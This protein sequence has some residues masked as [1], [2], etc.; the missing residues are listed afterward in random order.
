MNL[1]PKI[2][3]KSGMNY[4]QVFRDGNVAIYRQTKAG[5]SWEAFEV[6][7]IRQN[8]ARIVFGRVF[9][10]SESW[11]NSEEWGVRAWTCATLSR[12]K[13]RA[14]AMCHQAELNA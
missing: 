5:Q 2:F 13:G 9:E 7:K 10:A 11:P 12:A 14:L 8:K 1:L 3:K 4:E 6:G